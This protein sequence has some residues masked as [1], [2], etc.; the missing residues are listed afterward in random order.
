MAMY[1]AQC[2]NQ[3]PSE[4]TTKQSKLEPTLHI[5]KL[6]ADRFCSG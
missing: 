2:Q 6:L 5:V 4:D 1:N 3:T